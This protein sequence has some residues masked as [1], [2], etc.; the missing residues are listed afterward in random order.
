VYKFTI[1]IPKCQ[2]EINAQNSST[3]IHNTE[4]QWELHTVLTIY[5]EYVTLVKMILHTVNK[6]NHYEL[7]L[8]VH[9]YSHF[10]R[11]TAHKATMAI[12]S[13]SH[14]HNIHIVQSC[15]TFRSVW[16]SIYCMCTLRQHHYVHSVCN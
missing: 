2:L 5:T 7:P 10:L 13:W 1:T 8:S 6:A 12:S 14:H 4:L 16:L 9:K 15:Q 11:P 3:A